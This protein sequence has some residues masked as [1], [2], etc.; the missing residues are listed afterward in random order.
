MIIGFQVQ[1]KDPSLQETDGN[2]EELYAGLTN[3]VP[4]SNKISV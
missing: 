1:K 2:F 3:Q 4:S